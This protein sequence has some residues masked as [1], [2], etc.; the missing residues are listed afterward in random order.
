MTDLHMHS[1]HSDGAFSPAALMEACRAQGLKTVS[2]TDHDTTAGTQEAAATA[3]SLGLRFIPGVE[4]SCETDREIHILGYHI[5]G[6]YPPLADELEALRQER[7]QRTTRMVEKLR[8]MGMDITYE[9]VAREAGGEV[10][11]RP[12]LASVLVRRGYAADMKDAFDKYI[13]RGKPAYAKRVKMTP[14]KAIRLILEAGGVPVL[15]HPGLTGLSDIRPLVT[16]LAGYGLKGIEAYYPLH[17]DGQCVEYESI[18]MQRGL[19]IT[20]GSDYHGGGSGALGSEKRSS[21]YLALCIEKLAEIQ[22]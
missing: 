2:L 8:A 1:T 21:N 13:A 16:E 4:L 9:E 17:T 14:Q 18:A 7:L 6:A 11:G 15:A 3:A 20:C 19:Y 5:N 22:K 10:V 12:H